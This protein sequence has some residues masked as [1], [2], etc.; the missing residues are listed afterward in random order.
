MGTLEAQEATLSLL[1]EDGGPHSS[2][3]SAL[4]PSI[5][6]RQ[7]AGANSVPTRLDR[8]RVQVVSGLKVLSCPL[9]FLPIFTEGDGVDLNG[10]NLVGLSTAVGGGPRTAAHLQ[11]AFTSHPGCGAG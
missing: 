2:L 10:W 8:S 9:D 11:K 5:V 3:G 7:G 6:C 4:L 1:F